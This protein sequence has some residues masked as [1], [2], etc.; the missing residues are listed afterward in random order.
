MN[1]K[2]KLLPYVEGTGQQHMDLDNHLLDC[3]S[4]DPEYPSI[5]RFYRWTPSAISLGFH[6]KVYADRWQ[7]LAETHN[8]DIVR[9]PSGGRAVLH[10]G[11]LT[12]A[13]ITDAKEGD[14]ARSHRQVYEHL[15]GFLIQGFAELGLALSYG[16]SG[17]G[18]IHNPSCFSSATNADLV[19]ADGR[20]LIGSAQVYRRN[21]VLQHGSI[22]IAPNH[23]LLKEIFGAD[24]PIVGCQELIKEIQEKSQ[25]SPDIN[26]VIAKIITTLTQAARQHFQA[27]LL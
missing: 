15:C 22:A 25:E 1:R 19:I 17:R 3:H 14:V 13:I 27:Q 11:D 10:W 16:K 7:L 12:Y 18:Y 26:V 6:Q 5:L 9:R 2:W 20:K 23:N 4:L 24:V 21:S 8:L